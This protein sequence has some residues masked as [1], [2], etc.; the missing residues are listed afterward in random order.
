LQHLG[1]SGATSS[2]IAIVLEPLMDRIT[3]D[4]P[5]RLARGIIQNYNSSAQTADVLLLPAQDTI[6]QSV[7][8]ARQI[9]STT[10]SA[11]DGAVVL[12][13]DAHNP[14]DAVILGTYRIA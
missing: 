1:S 8:V 5:Q 3:F 9:G 14:N 2:T 7:P 12:L 10:I 6:L 4:T 11:G 13:F